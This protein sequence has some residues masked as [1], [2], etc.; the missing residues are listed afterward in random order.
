[1]GNNCLP[2]MRK[3][4]MFLVFASL[5]SALTDSPGMEYMLPLNPCVDHDDDEVY[6]LMLAGQDEREIFANAGCNKQANRF[7]VC[8]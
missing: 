4:V 6:F 1:M 8:V 5:A 3:D 7:V 2:G